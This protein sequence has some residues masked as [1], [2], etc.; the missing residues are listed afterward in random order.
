M[1]IF[2]NSIDYFGQD[3]HIL[4]NGEEFP[5]QKPVHYSFH[6]SILNYS[7]SIIQH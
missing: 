2:N 1:A 6:T 5:F 4:R 3:L 7:N